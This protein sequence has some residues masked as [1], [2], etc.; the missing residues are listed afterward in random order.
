M[1]TPTTTEQADILKLPGAQMLTP[2]EAAK[3]L[4]ISPAQV[5][6]LCAYGR[7]PFVNVGVGSCRKRRRIPVGELR[8][9]MRAQVVE[10]DAQE[11][12]AIMAGPYTHRPT[13]P[14]YH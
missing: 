6:T 14:Q 8:K 13:I 2:T 1:S 7:L 3:Y 12:R 4:G 11:T 5:R 9:F 10:I